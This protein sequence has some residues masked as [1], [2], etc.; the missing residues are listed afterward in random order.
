MSDQTWGLLG[1]QKPVAPELLRRLH[2]HSPDLALQLQFY[3]RSNGETPDDRQ[4]HDG[5]DTSA[6]LSLQLMEVLLL[7]TKLRMELI[8]QPALSPVKG[9]IPGHLQL[10]MSEMMKLEPVLLQAAT[11]AMEM[12][13]QLWNAHA[14]RAPWRPGVEE[15][16]DKPK[17]TDRGRWVKE[18]GENIG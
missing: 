14:E 16:K 2:M 1:K 15:D 12:H 5:A 3:L 18:P 17:K 8:E 10:A 9:M 7:F 11:S 13:M 4:C 6:F